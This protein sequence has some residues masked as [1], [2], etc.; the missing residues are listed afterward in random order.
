[1]NWELIE[2]QSVEERELFGGLCTE[3]PKLSQLSDLQG[4]PLCAGSRSQS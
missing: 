1:M 3:L 2:V 4:L